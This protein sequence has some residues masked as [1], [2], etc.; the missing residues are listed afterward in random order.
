MWRCGSSADVSALHVNYGLRDEAEH[1]EAHCRGLC[2]PLDVRRWSVERVRLP[3]DR[4]TC[5]PRPAT[6]A[7][8]WPSVE[9]RATTRPP[10]RRPTRPRPCSTGWRSRPAGGR[11]WAWSAR[12]GRLVRPLLEATREETRGVLPGARAAPGART[13]RTRI[14][15]SRARACAG[16]SCRRCASLSPAAERTIAETARLLR[17][18]AEVLDGATAEA[19]A[20]LGGGPAVELEGLRAARRRRWRGWRCERSPRTRSGAQRSLSRAEADAVLALGRGA[21]APRR[22]TSAAACERWRSTARCASGAAV[23]APAPEPVELPRARRRAVRRVGGGGRGR[24]GAGEVT[25][26]RARAAGV[27]WWCA[28]GTTATACAPWGSAAPSRSRT[29]SPTARSRARCG[30]RCR[31]WSRADADRVGG[32]RGA[33]R[34]VRRRGRRAGRDRAVG[35]ARG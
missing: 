29:C 5:R 3:A 34:A 25:L 19:L 28:A 10:T 1:D 32:R 31:W 17:D 9:P 30:A 14:P 18:E 33:G 2:A 20:G 13:R 11:C 4:A 6:P 22:S 26:S 21:A 27:R 12:R 24:S 35:A 8:G 16:S 7:T 23:S 15:A